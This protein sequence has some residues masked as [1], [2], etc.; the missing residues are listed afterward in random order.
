MKKY[1]IDKSDT[2][3]PANT[4]RVLK[5]YTDGQI[6]I[7]TTEALF[8]FDPEHEIFEKRLSHS[9]IRSLFID[10]QGGIWVG[11]YYD[12][13]NYYHPFAPTFKTLEY[14]PYFNSLNDKVVSC[15]VEE[16]STKNLWIGTNDG[17]VNYYNRQKQTFSYYRATKQGNG[18]RSNNIKAISLDKSGNIYVGTHS[19]GLSYIH[20]KTGK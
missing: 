17:G 9:S 20:T 10:N 18:L 12:G 3:S 5:Q 15:I 14:S 8:S 13:I 19:G 4:V 1:Q 11:T 6:W 7:G 16:P 2:F